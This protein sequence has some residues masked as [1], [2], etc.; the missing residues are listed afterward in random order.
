MAKLPIKTCMICNESSGNLAWHVIKVHNISSEEYYVN[1]IGEKSTYLCSNDNCSNTTKYRN[2]TSGFSPYCSKACSSNQSN[3]DRWKLTEY[4]DK[5][6]VHNI[7]NGARK[8]QESNKSD[9]NRMHKIQMNSFISKCTK[10]NVTTALAYT[11]IYEDHFK[12]GICRYVEKDLSHFY[13]RL[14]TI[15]VTSNYILYEGSVKDVANLEYTIKLNY[16]PFKLSE[17]FTLDDYEEIKRLI[18]STLV[19]IPRID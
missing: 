16:I 18:E 14:H 2:L 3:K 5:M 8:M 19:E 4:R 9:P 13:K 17:Y 6:K 15:G 10:Y 7:R 1:Y 11:L 12:L